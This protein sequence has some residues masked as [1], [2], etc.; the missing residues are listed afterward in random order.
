MPEVYDRQRVLDS[1]RTK[2]PELS[3]YN[4]DTV[5]EVYSRRQELSPTG[6]PTIKKKVEEE[7]PIYKPISAPEQ[8]SAMGRFGKRLLEAA[9]PLGMYEPEMEEAEGFGE[10][11]AGAMGSGIGFFCRSFTFYGSNWRSK[12]SYKSRSKYR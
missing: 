12:C 8:T 2:I 11:F 3:N 9:I 10:Q 6:L 7:P 4:D 1:L 5:W